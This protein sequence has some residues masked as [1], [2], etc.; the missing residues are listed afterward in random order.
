MRRPLTCLF[1]LP[2]LLG[3]SCAGALP[4]K[5]PDRPDA[6]GGLP[7]GSDGVDPNACGGYSTTNVGRKIKTF[8]EATVRLDKAITDAENYVRDTCALMGKELAMD[9]GELKADTKTV[10]NRVSAQLKA[11]LQA[12]LKAKAE[13]D[14]DYKPAVC[15]VDASV[16][17][18]VRGECEGSAST[19]SGASSSCEGAAVV[20]ASL[21]ARCEPAELTVTAGADVTLDK[22]KLGRAVKAIEAG[23]PRL[24]LIH[25]KLV[26]P[27]TAAV[28][29]W[30]KAAGDLVAAGRSILSDVGDQV[31]C[32]SGQLAAAVDMLA[33]M[34]ASVSVSIE[35]SVEVSGSAGAEI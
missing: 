29:G 12:G 33:H 34:E 22:E 30:G 28:K 7:G 20:E 26:G 31:L 32:V 3:L 15:T 8:L 17:A 25:A 6:P 10:C 5:V 13:L 27:V 1:A 4:G 11:H 19:G 24:L 2:L 9:A 35:V 23:V 16:G 18:R 21:E 14:I